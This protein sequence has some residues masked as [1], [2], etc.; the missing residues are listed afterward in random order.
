MTRMTTQQQY[1]L[2]HMREAA[3]VVDLGARLDAIQYGTLA[4]PSAGT[5]TPMTPVKYSTTPAIGT[6]TYV[7]ANITLIQTLTQDI[8]TGITN[9]DYPRILTVKG[10]TNVTGNVVI[11]GTDINDAVLTETIASNGAAEVL[12]TKAFKTVTNINV[13]PYAVAGTETIS[14]GVGNK[15]GFPIAV[16]NASTVTAKTFDG[17]ADSTTITASATLALSLAAPAG[18][19]NGAKVYELIFLA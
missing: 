13:P 15:I 4:T 1:D 12:G 11:T 16:P 6:A 5:L 9:P 8:K 19:F 7:H 17:S 18:T 2:T 14:I 10:V 3:R